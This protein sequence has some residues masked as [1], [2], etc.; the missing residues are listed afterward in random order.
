[1]ATRDINR[2]PVID[3]HI[4]KKLVGWL[5]RSDIVKAYLNERKKMAIEIYED[6]A[7]EYI[8]NQ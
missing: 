8:E 1:M 3:N 6:S 4:T 5:T 7:F 2:L